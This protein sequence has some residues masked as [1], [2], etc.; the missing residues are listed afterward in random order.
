MKRVLVTGAAGFIGANLA[1]HLLRDGHEVS[2]LVRPGADLWRLNDIRADI[3]IHAAVL[4]DEDLLLG[5]MRQIRPDWIFHLAA[6]GAYSWQMDPA[7]IFATNLTGTINLV[8]ALIQVGFETFV[9]TGTSSE[10]GYKDHA[11]AET[12]SLEPNSYYAVSKAS[13]AWFC[14]LTA[15]SR[16]MRIPTLR[17]YNVY[18]PYE[19]PNRLI[20]ALVLCGLNGRLPPLVNPN[21]ARDLVFVE[22]I[23]NAYLLAASRPLADW[24]AVYNVGTGVQMKISEIVEV[25][26]RVL[27]VTE[28][29]VWGSM[30]NRR[31]DTEIW[32]ANSRKIQSE[33]GWAPQASFETGLR[34]TIAW[35]QENPSQLALYRQRYAPAT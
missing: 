33:L 12:E 29:P 27:N 23:C 35:F 8:N 18:G 19:E 10:Y 31:W 4:N 17:I 14:Q 9:N 22:D 15:R 32:M 13:A 24:G 26:R 11:P 30:A 21:I 7:R 2:A 28:S 1:R 6:F 34:K 3:R 16:K 25:V 20:P 5:Q